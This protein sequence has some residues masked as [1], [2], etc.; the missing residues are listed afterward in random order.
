MNFIERCFGVSPD[1]GSG[2]LEIALF[3]ALCAAVV[4]PF[5][6]G[7]WRTAARQLLRRR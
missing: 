1:G 5:V 7:K 6:V 4:G 3:C 2:S